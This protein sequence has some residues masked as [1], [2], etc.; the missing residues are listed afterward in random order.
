MSNRKDRKLPREFFLLKEN[1]Y[2][3]RD[4]ETN[5]SVYKGSLVEFV[6]HELKRIVQIP[7][8][9]TFVRATSYGPYNSYGSEDSS[10]SDIS[11]HK[12]S[13]HQRKCIHEILYCNLG[14]E[15]RGGKVP[16]NRYKTEHEEKLEKAIQET[17][18]HVIPKLCLIV[19]P[20]DHLII[21]KIAAH[22]DLR[23][24]KNFEHLIS[25]IL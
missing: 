23:T 13:G 6:K 15:Y 2:F 11:C 20:L 5:G 1:S 21:K 3:C 7:K 4:K 25:T 9:G 8:P 24:V 14:K 16:M 18:Y 10:D 19:V 12:R 17:P 22:V